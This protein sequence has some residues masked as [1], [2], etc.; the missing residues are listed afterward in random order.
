[1]SG[2]GVCIDR[3]CLHGVIADDPSGVRESLNLRFGIH[4]V[5]EAKAAIF[6]HWVEGEVPIVEDCVPYSSIDII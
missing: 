3:L 2:R 5:A 1:M 6:D 4:S